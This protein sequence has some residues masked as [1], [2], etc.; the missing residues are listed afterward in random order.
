[1]LTWEE[2]AGLPAELVEVGSHAHHHRPLDVLGARDLAHEVRDSRRI[3]QER[4][5]RAPESF[6]YPHGYAGPRVRRAVRD[7]GFANACVVGRRVAEARDDPFAV[8]RLQVTAGHDEVGVRTLVR[9]GEPGMAPRVKRVAAAPWRV[10]RRTVYAT[11]GRI[12]T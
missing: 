5:G 10:A 8:P 6:C 4:T 2:I 1:L 7:A 3:L 11:T 12:L 9:L